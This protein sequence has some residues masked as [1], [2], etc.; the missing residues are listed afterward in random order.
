[1]RPRRMDLE[2]YTSKQNVHYTSRHMLTMFFCI[3]NC[4]G[5]ATSHEFTGLNVLTQ[6]RYRVRAI[7]DVGPGPWSPVVTVAT[8][9]ECT[10]YRSLTL[11]HITQAHTHVT[12]CIAR[13]TEI[14]GKSS[15]GYSSWR[16]W[17][18]SDH[19]RCKVSERK[20]CTSLQY[21]LIWCTSA[22][23]NILIFPT[24]MEHPRLWVH[25]V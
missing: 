17:N 3:L 12:G 13:A 6:Y 20:K 22:V 5:Y 7:N 11:Q 25:A 2:L 10:H 21:Y 16:H 18:D 1:M 4:S 14:S 23:L 15:Q 24:S 19:P 8:T 9:S